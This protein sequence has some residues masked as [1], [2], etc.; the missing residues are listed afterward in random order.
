M[1]NVYLSY[2]PMKQIWWKN[3][4]CAWAKFHGQKEIFE[5]IHQSTLLS[6]YDISPLITMMNYPYFLLCFYSG[7]YELKPNA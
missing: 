5:R 4:V 2:L 3:A 1:V 6:E 7:E